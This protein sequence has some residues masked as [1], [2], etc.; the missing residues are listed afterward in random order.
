M[1]DV[2]DVYCDSFLVT[3]GPYGAILNFMRSSPEPSSPGSAPK[4]DRVSTVRMSL[5]HLKSMTFILH[6]QLTDMEE[7]E[8]LNIPLSNS[9]LNQMK[10]APEDWERF[11]HKRE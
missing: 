11:W 3:T 9:T 10:I 6:R 8:G 7:N 2:A 4:S 5:E 1:D